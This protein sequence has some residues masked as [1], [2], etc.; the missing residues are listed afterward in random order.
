[1]ARRISIAVGLV[2]VGFITLL[3]VGGTT[4]DQES[5]ELLGRRVPVLK[6]ESLAGAPYDIDAARGKWV[7]V[8]FF[9]TW[10]PPCIAEHPDLVALEEWGAR[11]D[12]LDLVSVV[13]ND[14]PDAVAEFFEQ[15]GG[16]WPVLS[17]P[18]TSVAFQ[19]R[20]V[21]ESFLVD[22][23]GVVRVHYTGG[24]L[25]SDVIDTIEANE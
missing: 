21:P 5:S 6:G 18:A 19:I 3:A 22:P 20:A 15:R 16:S 24:I 1:M 14:Q 8:N 7:V 17:D 13:F 25:A 23:T 10:C 2:L 4:P 11:N 9:A 12:R